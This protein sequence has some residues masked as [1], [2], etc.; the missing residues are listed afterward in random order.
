MNLKVLGGYSWQE[1]INEGFGASGGN[2]VTD[3]FT[4]NNLGGALDFANGLGNIYSY[5][6]Q[7]TLIAFFGRVNL[8]V[9]DTYF[10]MASYRYEGNSAFGENE[11]WGGFPAVSAGVDI[12]RLVDI[13]SFDQLKFRASYGVTGTLPP[14]SY[15][16]LRRLGP[17]GNAFIDGEFK[18]AFGPV[19]NPNPNLR[20][21]QKAEVDI[22]VDFSLLDYRLTGTLDWYQRRTTDLILNAQ[23]PVPPNTFD[24]TWTNVGEFT[25]SGFEGSINYLAVNSPNFTY[26][27]GVNFATFSTKLVDYNLAGGTQRITNLG[28]PGQNGTFMILVKEGDPIGQ[29][30]GPQHDND[31]PVNADGSWNIID[32]N[33]DG[34][35]NDDDDVVIG[36]GL[37]D[38]T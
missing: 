4:Y 16:S 33:G 3:E 15:L 36:N 19:S 23:V 25:N 21:E 11:K 24:R 38:F 1:N 8:A 22:G 13:A 29:I 31:N 27:P 17:V 7:Q 14:E 35:I 18:P 37:P 2:F 32:Q 12:D 26:T 34:Q 6:N 28:A 20:W 30:Y 9:N 10:F 5:K